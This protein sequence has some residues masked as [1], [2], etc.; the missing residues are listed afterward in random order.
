M[1]KIAQQEGN[2]NKALIADEQDRAAKVSMFNVQNEVERQK[3]NRALA[4]EENQYAR[5]DKL[6]ALQQIGLVTAGNYKDMMMYEATERLAD[7]MQIGGEYTR[8]KFYEALKSDPAFK[9][10]SAMAIKEF[11]NAYYNLTERPYERT[12]SNESTRNVQK[13]GGTR[14]YTSRLGELTKRKSLKFSK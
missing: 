5:E 8:R 13:L 12:N 14:R 2:I 10:M 1:L 6:A 4:K 11:A 9:G 7:A 3:F